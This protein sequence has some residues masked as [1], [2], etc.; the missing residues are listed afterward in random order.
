MMTHGMFLA[1]MVLAVVLGLAELAIP[2]IY[3]VFA[4]MAA[5]IVG[6]ATIAI[7]ALP[8]TAQLVLFCFWSVVTSLIA[9]RWYGNSSDD[10]ADPMLNDRAAR[11]IGEIVTVTEAIAQNQGRVKLGDSEWMARGPDLPAGTRARVIG[12]EATAV[13]VERL[14]PSL[15]AD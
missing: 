7:P 1:W 12:V 4:A 8:I 13:L 6:V 14:P 5:A 11:L 9:Y 3:L 10:T 15:P 2:G